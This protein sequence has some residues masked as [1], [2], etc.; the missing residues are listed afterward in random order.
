MSAACIVLQETRYQF[1]GQSC[2]VTGSHAHSFN[3]FS[4]LD[5]LL[6]SS[7][8]VSVLQYQTSIN[9]RYVAINW[10]LLSCIEYTQFLY[11]S[12]EKVDMLDWIYALIRTCKSFVWPAFGPSRH[13]P[14]QLAGFSKHNMC[15]EVPGTVSYKSIALLQPR[16]QHL[17][18][19]MSCFCCDWW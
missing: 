10:W 15:R 5:H 14:A 4:S 12:E 2:S 1:R 9:P 18:M 3:D 11:H 6:S 19:T 7:L 8:E 13:S 17:R 16:G